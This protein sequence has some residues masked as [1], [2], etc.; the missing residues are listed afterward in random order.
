MPHYIWATLA[1]D[2]NRG[3]MNIRTAISILTS[4]VLVGCSK[5]GPGKDKD[6]VPLE[7]GFGYGFHSKGSY[8]M[9]RVG[10]ADL[11]YE[12]TNGTRI[13]VWP[14]IEVEWV[15]ISNNIVVLLGNKAKLY[16]DGRERLT[17]R[18]I[19]FEAPVGP[20][21]DV[22]DQV[23]QNWCMKSGIQFTNVM[24]DSYVDLE[25]TNGALRLDF[26][27]IQRG[28]RGP[29]TIDTADG[30]AIISWENVKSIM[31]D[32]KKDGKLEKERWSGIE[33][34]QKE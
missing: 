28:L 23:M 5:A 18:L 1:T 4:V 14:Y 20:A 6:F 12:N 8:P 26:V 22:T 7:N 30:A 21:M 31:K 33:Y 24:Q 15:Q 32:V 16:G 9:H 10:W 11:Q 17:T 27:I 34:L 19:S 25:K 13:V 2:L 29:A 3:N